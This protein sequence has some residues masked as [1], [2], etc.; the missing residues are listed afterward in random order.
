MPDRFLE[1]SGEVSSNHYEDPWIAAGLPSL[2]SQRTNLYEQWHEWTRETGVSAAA[3]TMSAARSQ[4]E[5]TVTILVIS[6]PGEARIILHFSHQ[7]RV[8]D[9]SVSQHGCCHQA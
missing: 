6:F 1:P 7:L 8:K 4:L 5:H 9:P 3:E 2:H